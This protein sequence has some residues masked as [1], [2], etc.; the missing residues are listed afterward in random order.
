[1]A[2]GRFAA[3]ATPLT[4]VDVMAIELPAAA[5][6]GAAAQSR[7]TTCSV[8]VTTPPET[9]TFADSRGRDGSGWAY[10]VGQ[11]GAAAVGG[12]VVG[13]PTAAGAKEDATGGTALGAA[14]L[15]DAAAGA[16][17]ALHAATAPSARTTGRV[18]IGRR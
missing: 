9:V 11:A 8:P 10:D 12:A 1:V 16:P 15:G 4:L 17:D 18:R 2:E 6:R 5:G 7:K 3:R 13:V 14:A